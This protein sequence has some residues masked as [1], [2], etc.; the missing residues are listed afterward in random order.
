MK[1]CWRIFPE[2]IPRRKWGRQHSTQG[3]ADSLSS[4][5]ILWEALEPV[6][7]LPNL[8][9]EITSSF[10]AHGTLFGKTW[11]KEFHY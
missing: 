3:E 6:R 2:D 11:E 9:E 5:K 1:I 4:Q 8:D 10:I 7:S